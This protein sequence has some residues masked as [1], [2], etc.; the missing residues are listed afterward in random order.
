MPVVLRKTEK[1]R[2][3]I[4]FSS[5]N[6]KRLVPGLQP[7]VSVGR[8]Y[9]L[10]D[11]YRPID[12][13]KQ[14]IDGWRPEAILTEWLPGITEQILSWGYPT[15]V[16]PADVG[17]TGAGC[18]DVDD[19]AVGRQVAEH[20]LSN[21]LRHFAFIGSRIH[22][23]HQRLA[24][25]EAALEKAGAEAPAVSWRAFEDRRQYIEY[26]HESTD[27]L[28]A[29]L[30]QLPKPVGLFAAHDPQGRACAEACSRLGL[31]IPDEVAIVGV[32]DDELVCELTH[33]ELSSVQ[34]PWK[35]VGAQAGAMIESRVAGEAFP[36]DPV[37]LPPGGVVR[38]RSSDFVAVEDPRLRKAL[39]IMRDDVYS[40]ITVGEIAEQAN[41]PRRS[42]EHWFRETLSISPKEELTRLRIKRSEELLLNTDWSIERIAEAVG[43][44]TGERFA[45]AFKARNDESP[46]VFRKRLRS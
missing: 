3:A 23:A 44:S 10:V 5:I 29:W 16:A 4:I 45:V 24:G 25:F 7:Y 41:M 13:L 15:V 9:W 26:W 11:I 43:Y 36:E 18:V 6:V 14:L 17:H 33:P 22:Y 42:L 31:R 46:S 40:G 20:F 1:G 30:K 19:A 39:Q 2:V 12:E 27:D 8:P 28:H 35:Q 37:I 32:N 34:I 38:R 21:G